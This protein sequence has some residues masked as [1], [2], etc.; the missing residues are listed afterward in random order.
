MAVPLDTALTAPLLYRDRL[1]LR[2]RLGAHQAGLAAW[3][4][5]CAAPACL[6][7]FYTKQATLLHA[8]GGRRMLPR[9]PAHRPA[10]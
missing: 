5:V 7:A 3:L 4:D 1:R 2:A 10:F 8:A 6:V 9:A